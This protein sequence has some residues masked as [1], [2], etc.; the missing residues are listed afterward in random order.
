MGWLVMGSVGALLGGLFLCFKNLFPYLAAAR[1]GVIVRKGAR[2]LKVRRDED[3]DGFARLL[4]NRSRSAMLGLALSFAGVCVLATFG[5]AIA[6]V[7]APLALLYFVVSIGFGVFALVC[8]MRGFSTGNMYA[9]WGFAM[10]GGAVRK[11]SPQWFWI[12]A[13]AN[14]AVLL[15]AALVVAGFFLRA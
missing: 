2:G 7:G 11:Q 13:L 9:F 4:A 10:Q 1:S 14:I 12:Y 15:N 5:L 3:P 6:G 8:L